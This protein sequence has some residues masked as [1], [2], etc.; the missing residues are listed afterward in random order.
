MRT[1]REKSSQWKVSDAALYSYLRNPDPGKVLAIQADD[2][3]CL[4]PQKI[5]S[6]L[7]KYW[8]AMESW[9]GE[10]LEA[11][12]CA[13]DDKYSFLLPFSSFACQ[14]TPQDLVDAASR[15][16]KSAAGLDAWS[17]SELALLSKECWLSFMHVC[18]AN[19]A[20][21]FSSVSG[22]FRRVPIP[23]VPGGVCPVDAIRPID[24]FSTLLRTHASALV[25][26][27]K[28]WSRKVI[29]E[30]QLA[31]H[32][33]VLKACAKL[34]WMSETCFYGLRFAA[35]ISLD[36]AK[37]FNMLS[38]VVASTVAT[39]MGLSRE[40]ASDLAFPLLV[41]KGCWRLPYN[42]VPEIF[43]NQRGLPQGMASSVLMMRFLMLRFGE[44]IQPISYVDDVNVV[45]S[46]VPCLVKVASVV[47]DFSEDFRLKLSELK[48]KVWSSKPHQHEKIHHETGFKATKVL[49]ALGA[50][51][52]VCRGGNPQYQKEQ[53]RI[54]ECERRLQ[55]IR[56]LPIHTVDK[57]TAIS[58]G[59]LSPLD[60]VNVPS[61]VPF[62]QVRTLVKS[63]LHQ[64]HGAPEIVLLACQRG[65]ID[66]V[67]RWAI[68]GL[69]LWF[70]TL[71]EGPDPDHVAFISEKSRGR[72]GNV[73]RWAK[74]MGIHI[75][76]DGFLL[77]DVRLSTVNLWSVARK[78]LIAF[79][80][81]KEYSALAIRRPTIFT[82]LDRVNEK[83]HQKL[84][85]GLSHLDATIAVK[86]WSG[87]VMCGHKRA[88]LHGGDPS[89]S[90][91]A[92][93]QTV[94]H[95]LW[96]CP[97]SE[98]CPDYLAYRQEL[99]SAFSV[100]HLLKWGAD[101]CEVKHW[102]DSL[103]RAIR[104]V[105]SLDTPSAPKSNRHRDHDHGHIIA[106]SEDGRYC[107]CARCY[108]TRKARDRRWIIH[109]DCLKRDSDP[110]REGDSL[111]C[112]GHEAVVSVVLWKLTALR[113]AFKCVKC[114]LQA[115][116]S[117]GFKQP[118]PAAEPT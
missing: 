101:P 107:Y 30:C 31:T 50:D 26:A 23:K 88:Q 87:S 91:G 104:I 81:M 65:T 38:P 66:P 54:Q 109:R 113:P 97:L 41:S 86:I 36:Y 29:P 72:L 13:L 118:C 117:A 8:G 44:S 70:F 63:V 112:N 25:L 24:V 43:M 116:A 20:S 3:V 83:Q 17:Q 5:Q 77:D 9:Q 102:T 75:S 7:V 98:V 59:C 33:G 71:Q 51:W 2:D 96:S 67:H 15:A 34:A 39:V 28:I 85:R 56:H 114:S 35:G 78:T 64:A 11:V 46:S 48:T 94:E 92:E 100:A 4:H 37:M 22:V 32:G 93:V 82:G 90:C 57:S 55:R 95:I 12:L 16:R 111:T 49:Q 18:S 108:I 47:R 1:W 6:E 21:L 62:L 69:R 106:V 45:C 42:A 68:S 14:I 74:K 80:K 19:P 10:E 110:R 60:Y 105:K 115:W 58:V 73:A 79:L 89:C 84:L 103:F 52:L 27:L 53:S 40:N 99:P 61:H 76:V